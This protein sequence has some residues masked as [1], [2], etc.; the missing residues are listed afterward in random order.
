MVQDLY[1]EAI[2]QLA[3]MLNEDVKE[4]EKYEQENSGDITNYF[5][6]DSDSDSEKEED[7]EADKGKGN[8]MMSASFQSV[9]LA[10]Q[11]HTSYWYQHLTLLMA[12]SK[13]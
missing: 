3:Q 1:H 6:S 5:G 10:S 13:R 8:R 2:R 11:T 4:I 12:S 7:K 9:T